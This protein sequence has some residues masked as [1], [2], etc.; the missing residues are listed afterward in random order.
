MKKYKVHELK[1]KGKDARI[2]LDM[3]L[4]SLEGT[5]ISIFPSIKKNSLAQI[6]GVT[7]RVDFLLIVEKL[8]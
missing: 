2:E 3:F 5:V 6:Y 7:E 4:N 8:E 1:I